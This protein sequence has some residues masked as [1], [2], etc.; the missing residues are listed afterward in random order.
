MNWVMSWMQW[1]HTACLTV[2]WHLMSWRC[3]L[4]SAL[5]CFGMPVMIWQMW[6]YGKCDDMANVMIWQM[7]WYGSLC[8]D[9]ACLGVPWH[10]LACLTVLW[11]LLS[12]EVM[13]WQM[14]WYGNC[15]DMANVMIWQMWWYGKCDDM[16]AFVMTEAAIADKCMTHSAMAKLVPWH[17]L[18]STVRRAAAHRGLGHAV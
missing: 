1:H 16:A 4:G 6:W 17:Q 13:I 7:W 10:A 5:A 11:Q 2:P 12:R 18:F 14:W 9:V 3:M 15:D 8:H